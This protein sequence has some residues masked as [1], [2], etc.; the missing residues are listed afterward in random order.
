M[1]KPKVSFY[2]LF[3][4]PHAEEISA[5]K[6]DD[7]VTTDLKSKVDAVKE[8]APGGRQGVAAV[9]SVGRSTMTVTCAL[10]G[11]TFLVDSGADVCVF[12]ATRHDRAHRARTEGMV[13]ANGSTIKTYGV[14]TIPLKIGRQRYEQEFW[15]ADVEKPILG[16]EF[17]IKND[18]AIDLKRRV[19]IERRCYASLAAAE[20]VAYLAPKV[21]S[22]RA[23]PL[24]A[25]DPDI[26]KLLD[27]FPDVLTPSF[28]SDTV[29]HE[30]QHH[31]PTE[32]SWQRPRPFSRRWRERASSINHG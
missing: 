31:V 22:I 19:L 4:D 8:S 13:A 18:L 1:C 24:I 28:D 32:T 6:N 10:S 30:V 29:A 20:P 26:V 27:E 12:P 23:K 15:V 21:A 11:A 25:D 14:R 17:F 5:E 16:A 9:D 2:N 7:A 3:K